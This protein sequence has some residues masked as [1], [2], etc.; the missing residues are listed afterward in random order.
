MGLSQFLN[1]VR[2]R[3]FEKKRE[4]REQLDLTQLN[5]V[6]R[7]LISVLELCATSGCTAVGFGHRP[8]AAAEESGGAPLM[9]AIE[10]AVDLSPAEAAAHARGAW[11]ASA[12]NGNE[13]PVWWRAQGRIEQGL[14][15]PLS[16]YPAFLNCIEERLVSLGGTPDVPQPIR[17][18]EL[19]ST[20]TGRRFAEVEVDWDLQN[21]CWI[22]LRGVR[23]TPPAVHTSRYYY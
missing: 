1:D 17:Y 9:A 23:T 18:I 13:I 6:Q 16:V 20:P 11:L 12:R 7:L 21:V 5:P 4:K 8:G 15:L 3:R 22:H 10:A 2:A 14:A 19:G